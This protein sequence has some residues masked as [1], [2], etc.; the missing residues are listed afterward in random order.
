MG[1]GPSTED[2]DLVEGMLFV[3][4]L[5]DDVVPKLA[6]LEFREDE[7]LTGSAVDGRLGS[8]RMPRSPRLEAADCLNDTGSAM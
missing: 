4:E 6:V 3:L 8:P 2:R 7:A 5:R 1:L